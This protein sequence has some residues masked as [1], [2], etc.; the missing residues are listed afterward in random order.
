LNSTTP[1]RGQG[2]LEN[3]I[4]K[5]RINRVLKYLRADLF[6][7]ELL[8]IGC[9]SYPLFLITAPFQKKIG[10]D[11]LAPKW[12]IENKEANPNLEV[13]QF[14]LSGKITLPFESES[15]GCVTSLACIEHLEPDILPQ[16]AEEMFRILKPKGQLLITTPHAAADRVLRLMS[17]LK[18]VSSE[19]IDEHKSLFRHQDILRL[20]KYAG[21]QSQKIRVQGFQMGLNILAVA[22]K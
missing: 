21:F 5:M 10:L 20:L 4:A 3:R 14:S 7:G 12:L 11:Q 18:L 6:Q 22:E 19:E 1:T 13:I 15:F 8:D 17:R 16:L 9:G 2:L